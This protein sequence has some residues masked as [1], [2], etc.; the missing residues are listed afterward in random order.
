MQ[1]L[2]LLSVVYRLFHVIWRV[3]QI[4]PSPIFFGKKSIFQ[5]RTIFL[6]IFLIQII[7]N[8]IS[9]Q[10]SLFLRFVVG[11]YMGNINFNLKN[12]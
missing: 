5:L 3:V 4:T 9:E 8:D 11:A 12:Q 6:A 7:A 1:Y 10:I 2:G